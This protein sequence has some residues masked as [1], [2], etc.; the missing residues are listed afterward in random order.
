MNK[1][2]EMLV[3]HGTSLARWKKIKGQGLL[4]RGL[5]GKSNWTHSIES[6]EDTIYMSDAYA[7]NFA[8]ASLN[9]GDLSNDHAV[10][11]E[12]DTSLLDKNN[13][14]ADE[15]AL[16]QV[17][18]GQDGLPR[19]WDMIQ[20]TRH[21]RGIVEKCSDMGLGFEWSM[22][23]MGTA[24]HIG[25]IPPSAFTRVAI[26]NIKKQK[27]AVY[28]FMDNQ[29]SVPNY[30]YVG[31]KYRALTAMLFG[32]TPTEKDSKTLLETYIPLPKMTM[33][34]IKII[35][36]TNSKTGVTLD[37][38][39]KQSKKRGTYVGIGNQI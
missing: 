11:I 25:K 23:V 34:G 37:A 24:G 38:Q 31:A 5:H 27:E 18:R 32:D 30:T 16:E 33:E 28:Q 8:I 2:G 3:Y 36:L 14:V 4:P 15:D 22:G 17:S 35:C 7:M 20:R 9:T 10:L 13:L 21:Y 1:D 29:V 39:V 26:I 19:Y 12:I 6:N